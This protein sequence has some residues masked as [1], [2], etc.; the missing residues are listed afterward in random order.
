MRALSTANE[1]PARA[2]RP[3]SQGRDGFVMGEGAGF[4]VLEPAEQV[5]QRGGAALA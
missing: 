4:L 5:A 1:D 3:F 2:S